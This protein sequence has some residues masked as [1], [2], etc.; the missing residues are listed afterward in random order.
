MVLVKQPGLFKRS[1]GVKLLF[2]GIYS[3]TILE[4]SACSNFQFPHNLFSSILENASFY[5]ESFLTQWGVSEFPNF[6]ILK[7]RFKVIFKIRA[8]HTNQK[9]VE[10]KPSWEFGIYL[11]ELP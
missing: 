9:N 2:H 8:Q 11:E 3:L 5:K 6:L 4:Y 10:R 7:I 1:V